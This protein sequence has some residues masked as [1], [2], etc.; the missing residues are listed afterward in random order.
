MA[1]QGGQALQNGQR[2]ETRP[3]EPSKGDA[4]LCSLAKSV[5][6]AVWNANKGGDGDGARKPENS[7]NHQ[8]DEGHESVVEA[9]GV[10]RRNG[11]P[12]D[13]QQAP[14]G[15]EEHKGVGSRRIEAKISSLV[16]N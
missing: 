7:R 9:R 2:Q 3:Q 4:G 11:Q 8:Q 5:S 15:V 13:N 1:S 14:D 16:D 12:G 10:Q 6:V